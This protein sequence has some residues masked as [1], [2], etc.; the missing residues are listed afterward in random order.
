MKLDILV[1]MAHPDDAE[2]SCGGTILK[3]TD[4]GYKVGIID[5]TEG[6]LGTRGSVDIRYKESQDASEILGVSVRENLKFQDGWFLN[7]KE[8]KIKIIQKIRQYQPEIIIANAPEDRHPDHG[9]ASVLVQESAWLSGLS[10]IQTESEGTPQ[11]PWRPGHVYHSIQ[12]NALEPDF[13][14]DISGYTQKKMASI[15]AYKSQ[16]FDPGGEDSNTLI[17]QPEFLELL[18]AKIFTMGN[19]GHINEAEGFISSYKP[20]VKHFFDLL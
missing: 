10:K 17:S 19:Y 12:F 14:V 2:L 20:A 7:D 15:L 8:H 6:E 11:A 13:V 5:L 4:S 16:F 18:R 3:H 9:R 1:I